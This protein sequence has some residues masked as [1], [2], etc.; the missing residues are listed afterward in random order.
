MSKDWRQ[1]VNK[2]F[3]PIRLVAI[4]SEHHSENKN[5]LIPSVIRHS[6]T[7]QITQQIKNS[8][9]NIR[10][11]TNKIFENGI[12]QSIHTIKNTATN[13]FIKNWKTFIILFNSISNRIFGVFCEIWIPPSTKSTKNPITS[14]LTVSG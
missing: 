11:S 14:K 3:F 13:T 10:W 12:D 5:I 9:W 1:I 2:P 4:F 7:S 6:R 8:R